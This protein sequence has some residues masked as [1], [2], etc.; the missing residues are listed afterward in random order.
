[1]SEKHV[2]FFSPKNLKLH[3]ERHTTSRSKAAWLNYGSLASFSDT[4][5]SKLWSQHHPSSKGNFRNGEESQLRTHLTWSCEFLVNSPPGLKNVPYLIW[6]FYLTTT[7]HMLYN[8][9]RILREALGKRE[10]WKYN[11]L[12]L[13]IEVSGI[14]QTGSQLLSNHLLPTRSCQLQAI[15]QGVADGFSRVSAPGA[16]NKR[17]G[18][19]YAAAMA[20]TKKGSKLG[21]RTSTTALHIIIS[22]SQV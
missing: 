2:F 16:R 6:Y 11:H 18:S 12:I 3:P 1:M 10:G 5:A 13:P 20:K 9:G 8:T 19:D 17:R 7:F 15:K 22:V 14:Q 21:T 4:E